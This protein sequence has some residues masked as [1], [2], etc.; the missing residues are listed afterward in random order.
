MNKI[1]E[2]TRRLI[3]SK[4]ANH[5]WANDGFCLYCHNTHRTDFRSNNLCEVKIRLKKLDGENK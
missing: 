4:Q 1:T 5:D 3:L 2:R